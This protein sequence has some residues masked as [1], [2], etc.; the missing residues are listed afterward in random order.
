MPSGK[1][2]ASLY[3]CPVIVFIRHLHR[4]HLEVGLCPR[5]IYL[6]SRHKVWGVV[7]HLIRD[8]TPL[9]CLAFQMCS[10]RSHHLELILL[11]L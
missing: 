2:I 1:H 9:S 6:A 11:H 5:G 3:R 7:D 10:L 8:S 4:L